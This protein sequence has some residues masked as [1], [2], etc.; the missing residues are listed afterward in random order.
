MKYLTDY[1]ETAQTELFNKLGVFFAF[2]L[3]QFEENKTPLKKNEKYISIGAGC[4][5]PSSSYENFKKG[6]KKLQKEGIKKDIKE[7]GID[8]IILRELYNHECFYTM[9]INDSIEALQGY[10]VTEKDIY[11]VF[12]NE[13]ATNKEL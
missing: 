9:D 12:R 5:M 11:A 13:I 10:K 7:N 2:S 4:Y 6:M 8:K 3:E 1:T